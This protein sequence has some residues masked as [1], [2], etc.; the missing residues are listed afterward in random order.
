M[1]VR[2]IHVEKRTVWEVFLTVDEEHIGPESLWQH[3]TEKDA[4]EQA[5]RMFRKN[6]VNVR[7]EDKL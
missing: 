3:D 1:S 6:L 4:V 2:E 7:G 5:D